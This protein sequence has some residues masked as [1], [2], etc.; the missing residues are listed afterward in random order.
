MNTFT[1]ERIETDGRR[2]LEL[3]ELKQQIRSL[4]TLESNDAPVISC[5]LNLE[6]GAG[7][8]GTAGYWDV[9]RERRAL[10]RKTIADEWKTSFEEALQRIETHLDTRPRAESNGIAIF[11]RGG[12][13]PFF[14]S[15]QFQV[16]LQNWV[17]VGPIPNVYPLV[18]LKDTYHRF[19][20]LLLTE[21]RARILQVN[22]GAVTGEAWAAQPELRD[23]LS[24]GWSKTHYQ[25][26][27][28]QETDRF[29]AE[30]I[31]VLDR[32]MSSGGNTHLVLA[33][34]PAM[35]A[36]MRRALP[37]HLASKLVDTLHASAHDAMP[38]IVAATNTLFVEHEEGESLAKVS[39]LEQEIQSHGLAVTGTKASLRALKWGEA[40]I[41]VMAKAYAPDSGWSCPECG[42]IAAHS[43]KPV[44]CPECAGLQL[45]PIDLK[46]EMVRLAERKGVEVEIVNNS[47]HLMEMGGVGCLLRYQRRTASRV[48]HSSE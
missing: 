5:Y 18:E 28:E 15:L 40:D 21:K 31:L 43:K 39:L 30:E 48:K 2:A 27:R 8:S 9:F 36:R 34:E 45:Q 11:A 47:D 13:Q 26:H 44:A 25:R 32:L 20:L 19:V 22:L 6:P 42:M 4:V 16:P 17:V 35:T 23:R 12:S 7:E 46:E 3:T 37:K 1:K 29:I 33:G 10:L 14:V 38:D 24:S 41:L